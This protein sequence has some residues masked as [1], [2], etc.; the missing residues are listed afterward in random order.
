MSSSVWDRAMFHSILTPLDGSPFGEHAL[1]LAV[2]ICRRSGAT[3]RLL[4]VQ[5]PLA[6]VYGETPLFREDATLEPVVRARQR[7]GGMSYL[8]DVASRLPALPAGRIGRI[9]AEGEVGAAI[10]EQAKQFATDLVV[11]TT[12]ARG[13]LGRFWLGSVADALVRAVAAPVLLV[14]G[15]EEPHAPARVGR[16]LVPLDG[17]PLAQQMVAPAADLAAA[18]GAEVLLLRVVAPILVPSFFVEGGVG[19]G[20]IDELER[21]D[22]EEKRWCRIAG[23]YLDHV[24]AT[25]AERGLKVSTRVVLHAQPA[26]AIREEAGREGID[27]IALATHGRSGLSRLILGSVADR[28]VRGGGRPVLVQRPRAS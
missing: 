14:P 23:K 12:H 8:N 7:Q 28:V 25:L 6:A 2:A 22:E 19:M 24:A 13:P 10:A 3:L 18:M 21:L 16:I 11:M 9:V 5:Q 15:G 17:S 1:P 4:H 26:E 27:L 20:L